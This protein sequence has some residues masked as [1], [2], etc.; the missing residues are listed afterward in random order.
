MYALHLS[1]TSFKKAEPRNNK[2]VLWKGSTKIRLD[3]PEQRQ[4]KSI[5]KK[6]LTKGMF[7]LHLHF[8]DVTA[9]QFCIF[10]L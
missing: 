9:V 5:A 1:M 3:T 7:M 6:W 2:C 8:S 10:P 4:D